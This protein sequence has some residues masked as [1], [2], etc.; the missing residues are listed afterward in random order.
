MDECLEAL[1]RLDDVACKSVA[2][3]RDC[4]AGT[5]KC[6]LA[7]NR[8]SHDSEVIACQAPPRWVPATIDLQYGQWSL[9]AQLG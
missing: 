8:R 3:L 2:T 5:R 6:A 9:S 4:D 7:G 1:E